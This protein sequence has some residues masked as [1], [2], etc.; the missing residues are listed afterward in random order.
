M[1]EVGYCGLCRS[2][3]VGFRGPKLRNIARAAVILSAEGV[4]ATG[5]MQSEH[6]QET[7]K[8]AMSSIRLYDP[9]VPRLRHPELV[10][11]SQGLEVRSFGTRP[12][13]SKASTTPFLPKDRERTP[14]RR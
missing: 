9:Y 14:R 13:Q 2:A 5:A 1:P 11:D 10:R 4:D 3:N 6:L 8:M 7:I 12:D